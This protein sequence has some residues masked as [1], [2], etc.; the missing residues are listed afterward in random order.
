M[1]S[2][3]LGGVSILFGGSLSSG[4]YPFPFGGRGGDGIV[5]V[6]FIWGGGTMLF[7]GVS[8]SYGGSLFI[9]EVGHFLGVVFYWHG[10]WCSASHAPTR[11]IKVM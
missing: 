4:G 11:R 5:S 2:I 10:V 9:G 1:Y 6:H 7:G 3:V 8:I